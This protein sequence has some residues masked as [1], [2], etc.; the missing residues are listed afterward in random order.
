[1]TRKDVMDV[2][3][4]SNFS[5][6]ELITA[7]LEAMECGFNALIFIEEKN[8][9]ALRKSFYSWLFKHKDVLRPLIERYA[10]ELP[11]DEEIK[12]AAV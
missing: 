12:E 11:E 1:M 6:T 8:M 10:E 5:S 4:D 7:M 2:I 3:I 9:P